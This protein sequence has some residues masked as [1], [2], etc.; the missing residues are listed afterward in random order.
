MV[1]HLEA[2]LQHGVIRQKCKN[3]NLFIETDLFK[4]LIY[5]TVPFLFMLILINGMSSFFKS[6]KYA[7]DIL[8][9]QTGFSADWLDNPT[10]NMEGTDI[11]GLILK[12]FPSYY[13]KLVN[14]L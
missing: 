11:K 4:E 9:L 7:N 3:V 10:V 1:P 13:R 14:A 8:K 5:V 2:K 6:S 12:V